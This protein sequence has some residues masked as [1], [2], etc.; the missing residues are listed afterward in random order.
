M[1][2]GAAPPAAAARLLVLA[3]AV[4]FGTTGTAQA[5]GPDDASPV[6]VGVVRA[7]V[8]GAALA[9]VGL[10]SARRAAPARATARRTARGWSSTLGRRRALLVAVAAVGVAAYQPTFFVGVRANGVAVG[11]LVALGSA[12]VLTGLLEWSLTR[13]APGRRWVAATTLAAAGVAVLSG[14]LAGPSAAAASTTDPWGLLASVG[15]GASYAVY[16]LASKGLLDAGW[17]VETTMGAAFG[18]AGALVLP[19]LPFLD[20]GWV[21]TPSGAVTALY[22]GVVP[23]ALAYL[24][25]ARG[26]RHLRAS[27]VSTLTLAEPLTAAALG[28]GLL[29]EP[30]GSSFLLGGSLLVTGLLVLSVIPRSRSAGPGARGAREGVEVPPTDRATS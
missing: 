23:T 3:A 26:L 24:L 4:A 2:A 30:A 5:L 27:E 16:T 21:V 11:T 20:L 17:S 6:A 7:V 28:I 25:F 18:A 19:V 8:G 12:P 9:L 1:A 14:A 29:G 13:R 22:L 15:A 10:W